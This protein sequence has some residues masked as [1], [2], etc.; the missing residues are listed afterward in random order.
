MTIALAGLSLALLATLV[1]VIVNSRRER[2]TM[3]RA[4]NMAIKEGTEERKIHAQTVDKM[5][6]QIQQPEVAPF[7]ETDRTVERAHVP[8]H[9]DAAWQAEQERLNGSG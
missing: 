1:L 9:D 2:E 3:L 6:T 7:L 8:L 5:A 4:L